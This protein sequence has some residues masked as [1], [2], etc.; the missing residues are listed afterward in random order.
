[1]YIVKSLRGHFRLLAF[2]IVA[3]PIIMPQTHIHI[4][5]NNESNFA[6]PQIMKVCSFFHRSILEMSLPSIAIQ[7]VCDSYQ[8]AMA[9]ES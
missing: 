4:A 1:M 6:V 8:C 5:G 7:V 3:L 2:S 9:S